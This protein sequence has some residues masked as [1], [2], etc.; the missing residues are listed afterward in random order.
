[1]RT[2]WSVLNTL[3]VYAVALI[4]VCQVPAGL[5]EAHPV[6]DDTPA[7]VERVIAEHDL[8]TPLQHD[9]D[10]HSALHIE[11]EG[12]SERV[13]EECERQE[14]LLD[15]LSQRPFTFDF[16][17]LRPSVHIARL[18]GRAPPHGASAPLLRPRPIRWLTSGLSLRGPPLVTS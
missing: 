3:L 12:E 9:D 2:A 5:A 8:V 4:L 17:P 6:D 13:E 15:D 10:G 18:R 7:A 11:A 1:M 14:V 16:A